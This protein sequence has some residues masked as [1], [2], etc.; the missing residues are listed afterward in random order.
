LLRFTDQ[1]VPIG[2]FVSMS[3][4]LIILVTVFMSIAL[5]G[6]IM[7]QFFWM[8]NAYQVSERHFDQFARRALTDAVFNMQRNETMS[9]IF[10][11]MNGASW[12]ST[13]YLRAKLAADSLTKFQRDTLL[14]SS[15]AAYELQTNIF[16]GSRIGH[17]FGQHPSK[18]VSMLKRILNR[19]EFIDRVV[20]KMF[21]FSSSIEKRVTPDL[22]DRFLQ[23]ALAEHG[24]E[25][26]CEFAVT[27]WNEKVIFKSKNFRKEDH[28]KYYQIEL[29]PDD[30]FD[31][32]SYLTVY[33]P[34]MRGMI[35]SSM[36]FI[37]VSSSV[38]TLFLLVT[39]AFTLYVIIRQKRLSEMKSDF[40]NNMTHEL[41][42]PISTI[43]LASQMLNDK[44][45]SP[46]QK[47]YSRISGIISD[48]SARLGYQV[49]RVLQM[50]KF[51][52][53]DMKLTFEILSVHEIIESVIANFT[54]QVDS[55]KGMLIPSLHADNDQIEGDPVHITNILS[56][57]LDNAVK[58]T[59]VAPEIYIETRNVQSD[60]LIIVRDNGIG[61]SRANQRRIF[62][63][64]FRV[65]TGNIHNVK[66]FGLGLSYVK[67]V[68]E[69]HKGHIT[70]ESELGEGTSFF[71]KLPLI[72]QL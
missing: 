14:Y 61:I 25:V 59:T 66:G 31:E 56:N 55:R 62:D 63:K 22:V 42:T 8:R 60:M 44:S 53:G 38:L 48:E 64:F 50:A 24:L 23:M 1:K 3:K 13:Q 18:N 36:G 45:I 69:E 10:D 51:D 46:E 21:N 71:I 7:L 6:L 41:K 49:E 16:F 28:Q 33:F 17:P 32:P 5:L 37:V 52:Q 20:S 11:E 2:I 19:R 40:V 30:F 58:Y 67:K 57:L 34:N 65:S 15:D 35:I 47:N 26:E 72:K 9:Y 4:R 43:S 12:D 27:N 54:L 39:F 29:F 68:V 70:L